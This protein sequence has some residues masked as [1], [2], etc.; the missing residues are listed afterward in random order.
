MK[1]Q[2]QLSAVLGYKF[3][4]PGLLEQA[5]T[6]SSAAHHISERLNSN[7]RL[8]FLGDRALGLVIAERIYNRFPNEEEG[9]LARRFASLVRRETL[10]LVAQKIELGNYLNINKA[11]ANTA[12]RDNLSVLA[13]ACEALIGALY[14]DGGLI[15]ACQFIESHW[16]TFIEADIE[17]PQDAKTALQEWAQG[18]EFP[19]PVYR[20]INRE[21]PSHEPIFTIVVSVETLPSMQAEG[22]SK[23]VAEQLAAEKTL[24]I[25]QIGNNKS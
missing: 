16:L 15:A 18:N 2:D 1:K 8:E 22:N 11:D 10:A 3:K 24:K 6:H 21:G 17:P 20:E 4:N 23:R 5:L 25:I 7:E 19:L 14:L 12:G 13:D 9:A